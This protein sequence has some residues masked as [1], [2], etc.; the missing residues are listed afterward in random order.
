MASVTMKQVTK[1]YGSTVVLREFSEVFADGE[2]ITLLGPSG[3]GKTTML[4]MIA[5]FEKPTSGEIWIDDGLVSGGKRFV[6]PEQRGIG[7][8]FQ[9]YAVWPHMN[10][11]GNVAYPLQIRH[12][13]KQ[14]IS[15]RVNRMLEI[16][17]LQQ[18]AQRLPNQLSADSSS[19]S[20]WPGRWWRSRSCCCWT[21]R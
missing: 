20:R 1:S 5:G 10:V 16:V 7:M 2:F 14:E 11:F 19:A 17:H 15:D 3:C 9:S 21:S 13:T 18:Y 12:M 8:V 6:P 4:R